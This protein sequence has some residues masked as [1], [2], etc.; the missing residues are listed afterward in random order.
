MEENYAI[1][2]KEIKEKKNTFFYIII[3]QLITVAIVFCAIFCMKYLFKG[4]Y[5]KFNNWYQKSFL[6]ETDINEVIGEIRDEI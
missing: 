2:S 1:E 5:K 3:V 6:C 4:E